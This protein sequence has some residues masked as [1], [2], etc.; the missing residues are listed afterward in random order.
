MSQYSFHHIYSRQTPKLVA[1]SLVLFIVACVAITNK[2]SISHAFTLATT[3][4]PERSTELYFVNSRLLPSY[5]PATKPQHVTFRITNHEARQ[6]VYTYV[7]TQDVT[8]LVQNT[9]TLNDGQSADVTF[10]FTIPT[11]VTATTLSV[12]LVGRSEHID[13]RSKS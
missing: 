10:A 13:F 3:H 1:I 5:S 12:T 7:V 9:V 8:K 6:V 11:P 2:D 4:Q